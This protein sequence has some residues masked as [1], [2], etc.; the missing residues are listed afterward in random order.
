MKLIHNRQEFIDFYYYKQSKPD[1]YPLRYPCIV[2][3]I[4]Q[5]GGLG[6]DYVDHQITYFPKRVNKNA[7]LLGYIKGR[8]IG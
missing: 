3:Q 4:H 1:K 8:S 6:G 5:D 7:F 2:E